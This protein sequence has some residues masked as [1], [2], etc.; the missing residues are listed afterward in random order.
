MSFSLYAL[1]EAQKFSQLPKML[2]D[3]ITDNQE[4]Q[5]D[6]QE[7]FLDYDEKDR[8]VCIRSAMDTCLERGLY[9]ERAFYHVLFQQ[10][11][12]DEKIDDEWEAMIMENCEEEEVQKVNFGTQTEPIA[13]Q[14]EEPKQEV[15]VPTYNDAEPRK[16]KTGRKYNNPNSDFRCSCC[17]LN[18][19]SDGSYHN[20]FKSKLHAKGVRKML[21]A[22][23]EK[24]LV[25]DKVIVNVRNK[26]TDPD[27]SWEIEED[28]DIEFA[29]GNIEK[30]L[31]KGQQENPIVDLFLRRK[32]TQVLSTGQERITWKAI[33]IMN[34]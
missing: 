11:V 24:V 1:L 25:G 18:L 7:R 23:R 3:I 13:I 29:F 17:K 12:R 22:M 2:Q 9:Q 10:E 15:V 19:A 32:H 27:L 28:N 20:H 30:Y 33:L 21:G 26:A 34:P 14:T 8:W 16:Y 5:D 4:R 31:E 6:F